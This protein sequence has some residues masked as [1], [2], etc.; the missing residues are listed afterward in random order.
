[1]TTSSPVVRILHGVKHLVKPVTTEQ[2]VISSLNPH[3][4]CLLPPLPQIH[5][6]RKVPPGAG[7]PSENDALDTSQ[8]EEIL[9]DENR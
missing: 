8:P 6:R 5:C 3:L 7:A 1:V 4:H 2:Q 9:L